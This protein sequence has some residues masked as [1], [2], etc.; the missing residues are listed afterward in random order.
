MRASQLPFATLREVPA[1]ASSVHERFL[2]RAGFV[3][4]AGAG[5]YFF[6][7]LGAYVL[8]RAVT[9]LEEQCEAAGFH[10]VITP[11]AEPVQAVLE[12]A[13]LRY[14]RGALCR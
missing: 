5:V 8:R 6:L 12:S 10:P 1:D 7:P 4:K 13:R 11:L 9:L 3:R 14:V 2:R